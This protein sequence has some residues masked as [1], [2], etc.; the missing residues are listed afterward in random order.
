MFPLP[1]CRHLITWYK[2]IPAEGVGYQKDIWSDP[3][4]WYQNHFEGKVWYIL[5]LFYF[6]LIQK[7]KKDFCDAE[8]VPYC[9]NF[10]VDDK[11]EFSH[12]TAFGEIKI[13]SATGLGKI[14]DFYRLAMFAKEAIEKYHLT[15]ILLFQL[16]GKYHRI[17][18]RKRSNLNINLRIFF[19][20]R[21]WGYILLFN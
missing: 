13:H 15:G 19:V 3:S 7:K 5:I 16:I 17:W 21:Y 6:L 20:C 1:F 14:T 12:S 11:Y 9:A 8:T 18:D 2:K 4:K 10:L